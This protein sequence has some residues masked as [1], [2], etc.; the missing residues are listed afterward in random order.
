MHGVRRNRMF[1]KKKWNT[2]H[3][4]K[5]DKPRVIMK[6]DKGNGLV[7]YHN[8]METLSSGQRYCY[9][10]VSSLPLTK[11]KFEINIMWLSVRRVVKRLISQL[12]GNYI[13]VN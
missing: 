2:F 7:N 5:K 4:L 10:L 3:N 12:I 13:Q 1:R 9:E 6:A 11:I 8:K